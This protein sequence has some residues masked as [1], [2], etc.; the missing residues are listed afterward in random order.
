MWGESPTGEWTLE[1]HND[2][3]S[4]VELKEWTLSFLGT[5]T[6]PQ[7]DDVPP[8]GSAPAAPAAP[9]APSPAPKAKD[10]SSKKELDSPIVPGV[11]IP[12]QPSLP[13]GSA[14]AQKALAFC[15]EQSS[16]D[17]CDACVV[18]FKQHNGRCVEE[19]PQTGFYLGQE[20]RAEACVPCYYSCETCTGP[21]DYQVNKM[22]IVDLSTLLSPIV[23]A[24][25]DF[26]FSSSA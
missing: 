13:V 14:D 17:W 26:F 15:A 20:K 18:G 3:R 21:N 16:P 23:H 12:E 2:G 25:I 9:A 8:P 10:K 5:P 22:K 6:P 19:C 1:V 11:Q 24:R 4:V 7:P